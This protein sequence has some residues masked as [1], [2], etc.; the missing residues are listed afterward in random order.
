M[1]TVPFTPEFAALSP[2][3]FIENFM[4]PHNIK[5]AGICVGTKWRFGAGAG[6]DEQTLHNFANKYGFVFRS[7]KEILL[8]EKIV[9]ST[10]I[11]NALAKGDFSSANRMLNKK[12]IL[13]GHITNFNEL[14]RNGMIKVKID[15]GVLPPFGRYA[16]YINNREEKLVLD[17]VSQSEININ[18][19]KKLLLADNRME[20]EFV[21]SIT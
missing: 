15:N 18:Y 11:R 6:G 5:L 19:N 14:E 10:T 16:V 3:E 12:Y 17:V 9:S 13:S 20:I 21:E 4:H 8:N 1:V 2:N 7:V